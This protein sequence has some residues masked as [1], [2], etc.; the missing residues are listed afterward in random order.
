MKSRPER[1][2]TLTADGCS[3]EVP[4]GEIGT[5]QSSW[6]IQKQVVD[7]QLGAARQQELNGI[8]VV[9]ARET[10]L[11]REVHDG[12]APALASQFLDVQGGA[13]PRLAVHEGDAHG[14]RSGKAIAEEELR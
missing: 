3:M 12:L 7:D 2:A 6:L 13:F 9:A 1:G 10:C 11:R 8:D 14:V 4:R 5:R